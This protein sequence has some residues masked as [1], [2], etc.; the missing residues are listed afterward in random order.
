MYLHLGRD[1][2]V[3]GSEIIG[4]F[5]IDNTSVSKITK[6]FLSGLRKKGTVVNVSEEL[7]KSY[8]LCERGGK[9]VVYIS[10]ISSATLKKRAK[11]SQKN[12]GF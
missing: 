10:Q 8:I 5:D 2:S 6:G 7:P 3:R 12:G 11:L 4:I 9:Q 1:V